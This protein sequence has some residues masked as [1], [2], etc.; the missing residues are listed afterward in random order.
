MSYLWALIMISYSLNE[1][2]IFYVKFSD[3]V[4]VE[5]IKNYLLGFEKLKNL[6]NELLTFYDLRG[7]NMKL[8][9][10]DLIF[11]SELTNKATATYKSV[12]TVFLVDEPNLTA[13]S[14]LFTEQLTSAKTTRKVF[15][16]ERAALNWLK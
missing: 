7:A 12:R 11:I 14:I 15:S 2:G 13:Y 6:P 4:S 8:T 5:D 3:T 1:N 10:N 16:T 9:H